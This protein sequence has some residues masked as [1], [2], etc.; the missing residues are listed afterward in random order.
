MTR[1]RALIWAAIMTVLA[2]ALAFVPVFNVIGYELA[3]TVGLVASFGA[4]DLAAAHAS[5]FDSARPSQA[6][7]GLRSGRTEGIRDG[8]R[9]GRTDTVWAAWSGAAARALPAL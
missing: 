3:F 8:L 7:D 9:S 6:R 2:V 5:S 1:R 4:A